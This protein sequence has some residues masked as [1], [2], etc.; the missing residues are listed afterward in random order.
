MLGKDWGLISFEKRG[1]YNNISLSLNALGAL[2]T[3]NTLL[4]WTLDR[5]AL[6]NPSI[7]TR[8]KKAMQRKICKFVTAYPAPKFGIICVDSEPDLNGSE[9]C[10]SCTY[11]PLSRP[12][13]GT[14][15]SSALICSHI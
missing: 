7:S 8:Q 12:A 13:D 15:S 5:F 1:M 10:L 11:A 3:P 2:P 14:L 6:Q 4:S 9:S